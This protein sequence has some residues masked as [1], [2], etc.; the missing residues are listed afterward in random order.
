[1]LPYSP[2]SLPSETSQHASDN[3]KSARPRIPDA[4]EWARMLQRE[5]NAK[6]N[7]AYQDLNE[8]P[9]KVLRKYTN[10]LKELDLSNNN[11]R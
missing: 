8:V 7:L 2:S 10:R 6:L 11:I 9:E 3:R 1:M 5:K 4:A